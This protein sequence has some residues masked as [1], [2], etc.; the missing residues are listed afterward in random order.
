LPL[1]LVPRVASANS[2]Q[3]AEPSGTRPTDAESPGSANVTRSWSAPSAETSASVSP[4]LLSRKSVVESASAE[5]VAVA[6][7]NETT[8]NPPA[9]IV[10]AAGNTNDVFCRSVTSE[11]VSHQPARSMVDAP[12]LT[13]SSQSFGAPDDAISLMS[14]AA[15]HAAPHSAERTN[16]SLMLWDLFL[17]EAI[18]AASSPWQQRWRA[19][20]Q[21]RHIS[22]IDSSY[23]GN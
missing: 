17:V 19:S 6:A 16:K 18:H 2:N 20:P 13:S 15:P 5:A 21:Q 7:K 9:S 10:E 4:S 23:T 22:V 3:V 12:V 14:T 8:K 1:L 11:S